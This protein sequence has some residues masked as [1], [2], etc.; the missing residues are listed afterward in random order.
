M[1]GDGRSPPSLAM[2]GVC[3]SAL[4]P[5]P[6]HPVSRGQV[7]WPSRLGVLEPGGLSVQATQQNV[8]MFVPVYY[9]LPPPTV[10]LKMA[11]LEVAC[12]PLGPVTQAAMSMFSSGHG[13]LDAVQTKS[14]SCQHGGMS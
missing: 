11:P 13:S 8:V 6:E 2:H 14:G 12:S 5:F 1:F 4:S 7:D 3:P 10:R 9:S